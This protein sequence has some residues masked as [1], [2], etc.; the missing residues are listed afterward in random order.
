MTST[1]GVQLLICSSVHH[2]F[3]CLFLILRRDNSNKKPP[4]ARVAP[5]FGADLFVTDQ[6]TIKLPAVSMSYLLLS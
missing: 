2:P 1:F 4:L 5:L 6:L 3:T